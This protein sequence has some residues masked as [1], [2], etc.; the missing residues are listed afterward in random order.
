MN[1]KQWV[2][3]NAENYQPV[4]KICA[5]GRD[6]S[7]IW[8]TPIKLDVI[9]KLEM[10]QTDPVRSFIRFEIRIEEKLEAVIC[11]TSQ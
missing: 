3:G 8:M 11:L 2:L 7:L 4:A 9:P 1:A 10:S 6:G 5:H